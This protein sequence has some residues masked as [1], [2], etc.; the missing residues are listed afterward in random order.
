[1]RGHH[2]YDCEAPTGTL[3]RFFAALGSSNRW[4]RIGL[5]PGAGNGS[6]EF[7]LEMVILSRRCPGI[8]DGVA[9]PSLGNMGARGRFHRGLLR[10]AAGHP[11]RSLWPWTATRVLCRLCRRRVDLFAVGLLTLVCCDSTAVAGGDAGRNDLLE[12]HR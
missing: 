11:G 7:F 6:C 9:H 12:D 10:A 1:M 5:A 2:L 3:T 4:H 8:G